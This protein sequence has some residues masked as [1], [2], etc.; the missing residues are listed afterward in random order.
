MSW[1]TLSLGAYFL[2]ESCIGQSITPAPT[3]TFLSQSR[4]AV[5]WPDITISDHTASCNYCFLAPGYTDVSSSLEEYLLFT[6]YSMTSAFAQDGLCFTNSGASTPL[7][8]PYSVATATVDPV[9]YQSAAATWFVNFLEV[10]DWGI[11]GENGSLAVHM[12]NDNSTAV[13]NVAVSTVFGAALPTSFQTASNTASLV[14]PQPSLP[15]SVS[16]GLS[17][18]AKAAIGL[19][20]SVVVLAII[21]PGLVLWYRYRRQHAAMRDREIQDKLEME[22]EAEVEVEVKTGLSREKLR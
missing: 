16:A 9:Q 17:S 19:V 11:C 3:G 15:T 10:P 1:L 13:V 21:L 18:R 4:R 2:A 20:V 8:T 12:A 5:T 7:Q 22:T 14:F 6:A